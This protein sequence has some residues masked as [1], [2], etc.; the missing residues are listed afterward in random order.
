MTSMIIWFSVPAQAC[1]QLPCKHPSEVCDCR[2]SSGTYSSASQDDAS[3]A[4][5]RHEAPWRSSRAR[6]L[7]LFPREQPAG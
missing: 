6:R 3:Q 7:A 5:E 4:L 2:A 1:P